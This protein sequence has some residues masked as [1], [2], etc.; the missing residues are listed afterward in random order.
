MR[1]TYLYHVNYSTS[2][3]WMFHLPLPVYRQ[4]S[5]P[6]FNLLKRSK[7][8]SIRKLRKATVQTGKIVTVTSARQTLE[9]TDRTNHEA[10][11][12]SAG[13]R[14]QSNDNFCCLHTIVS[15]TIVSSVVKATSTLCIRGRWVQQFFPQSQVK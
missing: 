2:L 13:Y 12:T 6:P 15:S 1:S 14:W 8:I 11:P 7:L 5:V 10:R 3:S 9:S 4:F